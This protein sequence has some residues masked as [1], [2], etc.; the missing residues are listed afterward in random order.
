MKKQGKDSFMDRKTF[1]KVIQLIDRDGNRR[2]NKNEFYTMLMSKSINEFFT[3]LNKA[4]FYETQA[5]E[6][7]AAAKAQQ[8]FSSG[9]RS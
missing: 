3:K 2:L 4:S 5:K 1:D 7:A 9:L 8:S 6:E